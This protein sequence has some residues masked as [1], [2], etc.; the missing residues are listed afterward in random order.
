METIDKAKTAK[1]NDDDGG[2][3]P[4]QEAAEDAMKSEEKPTE[5]PEAAEVV[6][7]SK[8]ARRKRLHARN[9]RFYR[10][11]ESCLDAVHNP[12]YSRLECVVFIRSCKPTSTCMA[13]VPFAPRKSRRWPK[14]LTRAREVCFLK[15]G[16]RQREIG[17][18][19]ACWSGYAAGKG[20]QSAVFDDGCSK[21]T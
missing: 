21:P 7:E 12:G 20:R 13:K 15:R 5:A 1:K 4:K 3:K 17:P 16:F 9:M 6:K 2:K 10:S 14:M 8:E 19:R 18:N 11:L